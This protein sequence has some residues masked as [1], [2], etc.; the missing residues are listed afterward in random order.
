MAS[1]L[2]TATDAVDL[3]RLRAAGLGLDRAWQGT[4]KQQISGKAEAAIMA[5]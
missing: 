5:Y 2:T 1:S 4:E 3:Q